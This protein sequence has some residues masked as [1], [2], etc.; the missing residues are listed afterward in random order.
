M[1]AATHYE[2][3]Y[4]AAAPPPVV[5]AGR[6]LQRPSIPFWLAAAAF[7]ERGAWLGRRNVTSPKDGMGYLSLSPD[8]QHALYASEH[9]AIVYVHHATQNLVSNINDQEGSPQV[10]YQPMSE[11]AILESERGD[12][13][14]E[15]QSEP[16]VPPTVHHPERRLARHQHR[17]GYLRSLR[18]GE[19]NG[20]GGRR[21]VPL[22]G[23]ACG[24]RFAAPILFARQA[25]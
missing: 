16:A 7:D 14:A 9:E 3:F 10:V 23:R 20:R 17:A 18:Q 21:L 8:G 2:F 13:R 1:H 25:R 24:G 19:R 6:R 22:G 15:D 12:F 5:E 11:S 4:T